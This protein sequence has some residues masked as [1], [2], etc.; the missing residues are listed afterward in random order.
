MKKRSILYS[1]LKIHY[2]QCMSAKQYLCSLPFCGNDPDWYNWTTDPEEVT[3]KNCKRK[4]IA[5]H[6]LLLKDALL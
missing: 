2:R 3:C 6:T 1:T 4:L 5:N